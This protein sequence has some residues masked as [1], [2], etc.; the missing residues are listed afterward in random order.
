MAKNNPPPQPPPK[1]RKG[2]KVFEFKVYA[3]TNEYS[4][5]LTLIADITQKFRDVTADGGRIVSI[6]QAS[7]EEFV[8]NIGMFGVSVQIADGSWS[9]YPPIRIGRVDYTKVND[10]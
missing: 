4:G 6:A 3:V 1:P 10:E 8:R 9:Y 7:A 5:E 2:I